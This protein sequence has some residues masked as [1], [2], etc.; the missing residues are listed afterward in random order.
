ML[1]GHLHVV[2]MRHW[3]H[4]RLLI[5]PSLCSMAVFSP[6]LPRNPRA[7]F[8][9][10]PLLGLWGR[11]E[12]VGG[13]GSPSRQ[14]TSFGRPLLLCFTAFSFTSSPSDKVD[15]RE[16]PSFFILE[17]NVVRFSPNRA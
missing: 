1:V 12:C 8:A 16:I 10:T 7:L 5:S 4:V 13:E 11:A 15:G 6:V 2:V 3:V 14:R 17:S 9:P